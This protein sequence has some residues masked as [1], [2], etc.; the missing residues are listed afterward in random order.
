M[1]PT[2]KPVVPRKDINKAKELHDQLHPPAAK[3][4]RVTITPTMSDD[5]RTVG[6]P[7]RF[8]TLTKLANETQDKPTIHSKKLILIGS[9]GTERKRKTVLTKCTTNITCN[10]IN[11]YTSYEYI[12][13]A[14]R[15]A[16]D[17]IK[18][19]KDNL[20]KILIIEKMIENKQ[21]S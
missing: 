8:E 5:R 4:K 17:I 10:N 19:Q 2:K 3:R 12:T 20:E 15:K 9:D 14:R 16:L 21:K 6:R 13:D 7:T 11:E 1:P 18:E